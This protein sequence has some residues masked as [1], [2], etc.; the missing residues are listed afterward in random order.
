MVDDCGTRSRI[1]LYGNLKSNNVSKG[2]T[3]TIYKPNSNTV[4]KTIT[5]GESSTEIS[6][7]SEYA[8]YT[9][10][11]NG[12]YTFKVLKGSEESYYSVRVKNVEKFKLIDDLNGVFHMQEQEMHMVH[13]ILLEIQKLL[14]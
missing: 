11:Q 5:V 3:I 1:Y 10:A 13:F 4:L 2:D 7:E 12:K 14:N 8:T 9:V 6:N